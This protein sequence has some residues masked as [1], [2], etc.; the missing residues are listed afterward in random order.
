MTTR[1]MS[2]A[3]IDLIMQTWTSSRFY[4][5]S[6]RLSLLRIIR[7]VRNLKCCLDDWMRNDEE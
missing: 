3:C 5:L 2:N 7:D 4:G 6:M 1:T